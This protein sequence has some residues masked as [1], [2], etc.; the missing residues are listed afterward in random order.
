MKAA[1]MNAAGVAVIVIG[2]AS[3][4]AAQEPPA[5]HG[6]T[7][8]IATEESIKDTQEAGNTIL[9][10]T[11]GG[12]GRLFHLK[13]RNTAASEDA[14]ADET[15]RGLKKGT[16]VLVHYPAEGENLTAQEIDRLGDEDLKQVEAVVTGVNREERTISIK[17][18]D[19]TRQTLRF[20][21]RTATDAGDASAKVILFYKDDTGQRVAHYFKRLS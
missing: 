20:S 19:G 17:L 10:R 14:A 12:I 9:S 4:G 11:A 5:I 6:V 2:F 3:A 7:G 8:T 18:A 15:L 1:G 13:G 21:D 16:S